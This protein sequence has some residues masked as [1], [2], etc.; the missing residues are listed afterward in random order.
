MLAP[1]FG[2][3]TSCLRAPAKLHSLPF[4]FA[5]GGCFWPP[6][7]SAVADPRIM[8]GGN[9]NRGHARRRT[10]GRGSACLGPEVGTTA[11]GQRGGLLPVS[12]G[13]LAVLVRFGHDELWNRGLHGGRRDSLV[14]CDGG[15]GGA[16]FQSSY[17]HCKRR[18]LFAFWPRL[19]V[20][21]RQVAGLLHA[22]P[23]HCSALSARAPC[24]V[25]CIYFA[26]IIPTNHFRRCN[27][28]RRLRR[29]GLPV[30]SAFVRNGI[31]CCTKGD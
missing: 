4:L 22:P 15:A 6:R 25:P 2:G 27:R 28:V 3:R 31:K 7:A 20:F 29:G 1:P 9:L 12:A 23:S 18:T 21:R 17:A 14:A 10:A 24:R 16:P 13:H 11:R 26:F 30:P 19:L 8:G 5:P